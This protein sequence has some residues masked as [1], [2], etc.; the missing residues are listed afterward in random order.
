MER[1]KERKSS[2]FSSYKVYNAR[3]LQNGL[4]L[5]ANDLGLPASSSTLKDVAK[6]TGL[7]V[8][9]YIFTFQKQPFFQLI[10]K[11]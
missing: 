6:L 4:S 11:Q 1:D 3:V 9:L 2:R 10:L 5:P 7:L 8:I